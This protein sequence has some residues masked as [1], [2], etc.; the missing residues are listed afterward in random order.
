MERELKRALFR[1]DCPS[2]HTLGEYE[3]DVLAP[4]Q[5]TRIAAHVLS[6]DECSAEL[7]DLREFL[8]APVRIAE[9][10]I[11][12]ARRIVASLFVP[13]PG[14]AYGSLRGASDSPARIFEAGDITVSITAGQTPGSLLGLIVG[15]EA[16]EGREV[17]L[18]PTHGVP[19]L[20]QVDEIGNFVVEGL[21]PGAYA[22]EI[23]LTDGVLV[24]EELRV[25]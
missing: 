6:C 16:I 21:A 2:P 9:P 13:K 23:E 20:T 14:L 1:F 12:R 10:L 25:D 18:V 17:R 24:I 22:L 8:A 3:L 19:T 5:R 11:D 7:A 4:E 15:P